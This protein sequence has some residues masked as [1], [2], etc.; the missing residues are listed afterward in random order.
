M[1]NENQIAQNLRAVEHA[2]AQQTLEG[3]IVPQAALDDLRRVAYGEITT[4]D[5]L[6][7]AHAR[8][9]NVEILQPR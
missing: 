6:R 5:A 2:I 3:L 1:L 7:N 9:T 8:F 4:S